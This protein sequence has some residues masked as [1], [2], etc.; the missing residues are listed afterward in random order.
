MIK[1]NQTIKTLLFRLENKTHE[2]LFV[3]K[4]LSEN[5]VFSKVWLKEIKKNDSIAEGS[6]G[7]FTFY[8][9]K[10]NEG[11]FIGAVLDQLHNLYFYMLPAYRSKGHMS[12]ALADTI[13]PHLFQ[14]R[15][16][17]RI[18]CNQTYNHYSNRAAKAIIQKLGFVNTAGEGSRDFILYHNLF[19]NPDERA[20]LAHHTGCANGTEEIP[21]NRIEE[22]SKQIY[23]ASRLL[24][25]VQAEIEMRLGDTEY[26]QSLLAKKNEIKD[27]AFRLQ[28]VLLTD[29][30]MA[31]AYF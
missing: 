24:A 7:P 20:N 31:D 2:D 29:Q 16:F 22:L 5:V 14:D 12:R 21:Q 6:D 1:V 8:F 23:Y 13:L 15:Y 11:A 28:S 25:M 4:A 10:S 30:S 9:I 27:M 26:A 18:S 3:S 17:Q 19:L